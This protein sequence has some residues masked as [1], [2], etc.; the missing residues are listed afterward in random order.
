MAL[1]ALRIGS[2]N[3]FLEQ[4]RD[5]TTDPVPPVR[6]L[7]DDIREMLDRGW[8]RDPS[9][10]RRYKEQLWRKNEQVVW[11]LLGDM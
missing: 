4:D 10:L 8:V 2:A 11:R 6:A 3:Y 5:G 7:V 1:L 9:D